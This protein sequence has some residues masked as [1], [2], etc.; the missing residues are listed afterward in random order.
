MD[1]QPQESDLI[2]GQKPSEDCAVVGFKGNSSA[3]FSILLALRALQHR[4]QES[5]GM[6][7]FNGE[8]IVLKKGLGLVTEVFD[9]KQK[10]LDGTTGI[11]HTRYSTAGSKNAGNAGP[12]L[13][14][15]SVGFASISHNGEI[16][17]ADTLREE[18]KS[19][20]IT[21]QTNSDTEVMLAELV[22]EISK[23]GF[24]G[25]FEMSM[26]KLRGGYACAFSINDRLF[27][28]RDPNGIRP[29]VI[30]RNRDGM[31]IASETCAIDVL[32]GEVIRDV[33]PGEIL[34][35]KD[36]KIETVTKMQAAN[37]AHC[38]FEY[39]YFSRPDSILD[40][41]NVYGARVKMGMVL[42]KEHP[43]DADMVIPVPDSG[44]SQ[45]IG[46]SMQSGVSYAEGLIKNRY[47]ERTFIMPDQ[48]ERKKAIRLKLNPIRSVIENK[49]IV[50][51]DDSIV[52]GN[53]M[54]YIVSLMK[55]YGAREVHVRIGSPHIIAPCYFGVDM[56]TK[57]QFIARGK[58]DEE[59]NTEIGS[60]SMAFLSI[61]GLKQAIDMPGNSLCIGCLTGTYP[62]D[63]SKYIIP[64]IT[65][66]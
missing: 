34:E 8:K 54:K 52:R 37:T 10:E 17:N 43:A 18:M 45:A 26:K 29:L 20:G 2:D 27:A 63:V 46:F 49:R 19:Q 66:F 25:G 39:V 1:F 5:A 35:I 4:G 22:R 38:M 6:A 15:S 48:T 21:F 58:T 56:K 33:E 14:N 32:E 57:D 12:F 23:Y 44:R 47:S 36:N 51:V 11:G 61:D 13:L 50:L 40:S 60:D 53:T 64:D 9:P 59:L 7:I 28:M 30:G 16:V 24:K 42:A 41:I 62:V 3:Y 65:S 55:K 31:I